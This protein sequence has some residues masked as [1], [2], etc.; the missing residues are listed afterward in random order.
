MTDSMIP[1]PSDDDTGEFEPVEPKKPQEQWVY[2]PHARDEFFKSREYKMACFIMGCL[3]HEEVVTTKDHNDM[4]SSDM[5][6]GISIIARC[7]QGNL[8]DGYTEL[9]FDL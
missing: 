3:V 2:D 8:V 9:P 6:V 4:G 7:L 5:S 1:N